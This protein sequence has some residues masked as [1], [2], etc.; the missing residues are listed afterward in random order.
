M[1]HVVNKTTVEYKHS[2][3]TP[4]YDI[5]DWLINPDLSGVSGVPQKYW[6]IEGSPLAV[7]EMSQAEK[8]VVDGNVVASGVY[9]ESENESRMASEEYKAKLTVNSGNLADRTYLASFYCEVRSNRKRSGVGVEV[10]IGD[11]VI[12]EPC[13]ETDDW[14]PF[15]GFKEVSLSGTVVSTIKYKKACGR[16]TAFIRRARLRITE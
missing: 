16:G 11:T 14:T 2:V 7:L 1:G 6:K 10:K 8:D 5:A 4:D 13:I 12:A 3:N 9:G 15:S